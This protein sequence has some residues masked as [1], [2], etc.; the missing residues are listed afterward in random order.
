MAELIIHWKKFSFNLPNIILEDD[1]YLWKEMAIKTPNKFKIKFN[2]IVEFLGE[3]IVI[4]IGIIFM[5]NDKG[6][7]GSHNSFYNFFGIIIIALT[8]LSFIT[9]ILSLFTFVPVY[10]KKKIYYKRL[11]QI[12]LSSNTY[13]SF[14]NN[15]CKEDNRYLELCK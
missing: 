11:M 2:F 12:L 7:S 4:S 10:F 8:L 5:Y 6:G 13:N 9:I 1:F 14:C 15:F 3:L